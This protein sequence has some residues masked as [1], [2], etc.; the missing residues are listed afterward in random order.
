[1]PAESIVVVIESGVGAAPISIDRLTD[2][3]CTGLDESATCTLNVAV[4][5]AVG[6]PVML[7]LVAFRVSPAGSEPVRTL[8]VYGVKPPLADKVCEYDVP[9]TPFGNELLDSVSGCGCAECPP[10]PQANLHW[11]KSPDG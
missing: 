6:V 3:V 9:T 10:P 11:L 7:P 4:P 1:V 2:C 8:H 5:A